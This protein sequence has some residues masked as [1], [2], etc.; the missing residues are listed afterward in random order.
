MTFTNYILFLK[1]IIFPT[2]SHLTPELDPRNFA[3]YTVAHGGA[4][5]VRLAALL[6]WPDVAEL[7]V[8]YRPPY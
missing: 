1:V 2:N 3:A 7:A 4:K 8:E 6:E 5:H